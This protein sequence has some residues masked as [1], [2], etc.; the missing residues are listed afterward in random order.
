MASYAPLFTNVN[1]GGLQWRTNLIGYNALAS[2]GSPSYYALVMFGNRLGS[3]VVESRLQG[4]GPRFYYS[5]T[6]DPSQGTLYLKLVNAAL[7]PQT[8]LLNLEGVTRVNPTG[9]LSRMKAKSKEA[10]N[11]ISN[12]TRIVPVTA[13]LNG[14]A[15]KFRHVA[16]GYS[17]EVIEIRAQ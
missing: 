2:Y 8:V 7:E 15:K 1:P 3:E 13:A 12:P 4:A 9:R 11:T 6:H 10:T 17:I 16:P 5:V 14:L